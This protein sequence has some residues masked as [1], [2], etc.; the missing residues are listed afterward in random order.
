MGENNLLLE[1]DKKEVP[2]RKDGQNMIVG[3]GVS[4]IIGTIMFFLSTQTY[5]VTKYYYIGGYRIPYQASEKTYEVLQIPGII[6]IGIG[7]I[8]IILGILAYQ[9][10]NH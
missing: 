2:T 4:A 8:A 6:L 5:I 7:V 9:K 1:S 10:S 3:G